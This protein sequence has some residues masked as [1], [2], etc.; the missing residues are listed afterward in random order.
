MHRQCLQGC[1]V[2]GAGGSLR[3]CS[4]SLAVTSR[5]E[6]EEPPLDIFDRVEGRVVADVDG[7]HA[8][9]VVLLHHAVHRLS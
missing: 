6:D 7:H 9:H 5:D 2:L 3:V 8:L 1:F 4:R